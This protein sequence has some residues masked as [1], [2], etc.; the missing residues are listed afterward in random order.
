LAQADG[1]VTGLMGKIASLIDGS[2]KP[3][4]V[5]QS[6]RNIMPSGPEEI[7]I[8]W[9]SGCSMTYRR[10]VFDI[11]RFNSE[12]SGYS[13]MEDLEFSFRVKKTTGSLMFLPN[14]HYVHMESSENRWPTLKS[15]FFETYHRAI[16]VKQNHDTLSFKRYLTRQ[17]LIATAIFI[18][19]I[20]LLDKSRLRTSVTIWSGIFCGIVGKT[21]Y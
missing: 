2:P 21:F 7:E 18:K 10:R 8:D 14:S 12:F 13:L 15:H 20:F 4:S 1:D 6:G 9:L 11:Q 3:G 5:L 17:S 16:F 19:G